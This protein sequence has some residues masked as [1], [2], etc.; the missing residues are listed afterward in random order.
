VSARIDGVEVEARPGETILE[1]AR[2]VGI[3]I[4]TVCHLPGLPPDGG[5]RVCLVEVDGAPRPLAACH[6]QLGAGMVVRTTSPALERLRAA[7]RALASE[8]PQS[9]PRAASHPYLRFARELCITCRRCLHVCADVQGADVYAIAGRGADTR[10]VFGTDDRFET[11][12]CTSCGACVEVCP[13]GALS[14]VDRESER[15]ASTVTRSTCG[16]CGVGCQLEIETDAGGVLR[17]RGAAGAAVNRGHTCAKGRYAHGWRESPERL[18][19]PLLRV[20]GR[21]EPVSWLEALSFAADR[22]S[23]THERHGPDALGALTSSRSTNEAAYLL[24]KLFRSR[25][26]TNNVDCCARVCH[27]S[28][29]EALRDMLGTGAAS[30]CYD[31][32]ERARL[33]VVVGANPSEAHPVVGARIAQALRRGARG[34]VVDPRRIDL[35]EHAGAFLQLRPGTNV[36]VLNA[37]AGL[38]LERGAIDHE[39]L[40]QHCDGLES[41]RERLAPARLDEV[42]RISG[43][44]ERAL[45][46]AAELLAA[47]GPTLFVSGLGTSELTQGTDSVRAL[48]N[49]ALLTGSVGRMGAGLLPLRGQNNVQGNADMGGAP[50]FF[51]GYQ[52]LDSPDVRAR[53]GELWGALPPVTRGKTIPEMFEAARAGS[54]RALWIQ[55]EDVAQSDPDQTRVVEALSKLELL[56]VQ[57]IFPSETVAFA[58]LVLPA[59]GWL[60][61]DGTFTNAE[62]RI[63]RVRAAAAPPGEARPD[64]EVIRDVACALGCDWR[65]ETPAAVMDEIARA[66]PHLFGGVSYAR[67]GSDGLQWP[68]P[69]ASHSGTARLHERGFARGR[70]L[71]AHVPFV[72]SPES[73]VAGF[74]YRL[75]TG[76]VLHHYNVGTMTRRTPSVALVPGDCL[77]IHADDARREGIREGAEVEV[78]S[79]WGLCRAR[80]HVSERVTPGTL[81]LSFHFPETHA[82]RVVGPWQ[83]PESHCPEYK[84]TAVRIRVMGNAWRTTS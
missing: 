84:L 26:G 65:Q 79:R 37:L 34:I 11:S 1:A 18:T 68:V 70:V 52:S 46:E 78:E 66:A 9:Q 36:L 69:H 38:L 22:L 13:T 7:V 19:R 62:R 56:V 16:Y 6:A 45:R 63:Q 32:I 61:Q 33:I 24:Q 40:A 14:D 64:W 3:E 10:L 31:D 81:F 58:H 49:L 15:V 25:F 83:D 41:L 21:L 54:L 29:A 12:P 47:A 59:A 30:A 48:C 51:T 35:A 8:L 28:T 73:D 50:N 5:C 4:P 67:L 57:E 44:P 43:V 27:A 53:L 74:P 80:A 55:G 77:E 76:R 42:T 2:R 82:N 60:E 20:N 23:E 75:I 17:V 39:Y 71:L 72:A